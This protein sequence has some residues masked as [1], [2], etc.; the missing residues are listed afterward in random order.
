ML[1]CEMF[2]G[3]DTDLAWAQHDVYSQALRL[4]VDG[5]RSHFLNACTIAGGDRGRWPDNLSIDH[6]TLQ[7][8]HDVAAAAWRYRT[9]PPQNLL[10]LDQPRW[11]DAASQTWL[12][13]LRREVNSWWEEPG[14]VLSVAAILT[15][16]NSAIGYAGELRLRKALLLR[17]SDVPWE[18]SLTTLLDE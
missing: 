12:S 7:D 9:S 11:G 6:R 16:Q 18:V 5:N 4:I 17:Y 3:D 14:L 8:A 1:V 13:W 2:E 10:P 15:H